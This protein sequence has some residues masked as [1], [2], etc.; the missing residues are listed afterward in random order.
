MNGICFGTG[1]G[2]RNGKALLSQPFQSNAG[3]QNLECK[4]RLYAF[5]EIYYH[6]SEKELSRNR[7]AIGVSCD[8]VSH[9]NID[10]VCIRQWDR[11]LD[12]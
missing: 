7:V 4:T 1:L 11:V 12:N 8:P 6:F 2:W 5:D 3:I 9:V 10:I